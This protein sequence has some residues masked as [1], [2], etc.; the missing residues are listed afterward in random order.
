M[1]PVLTFEQWRDDRL[2][3]TTPDEK[4]TCPN[5]N[6]DGVIYDEC[7]CCGHE[8]ED[9]CGTCESDG[10]VLWADLTD[11]EKEK[12][13]SRKRYQDAVVKDITDLASWINKSRIP[14]LVAHGFSVYYD[15]KYKCERVINA[16]RTEHTQLFRDSSYG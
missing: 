16:D 9:N 11:K 6:G 10:T 13:L 15:I 7:S 1:M 5:C 3:D 8:T 12:Y 4:V 14:M 2:K